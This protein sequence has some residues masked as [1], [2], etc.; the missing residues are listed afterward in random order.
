MW[1]V[2]QIRTRHNQLRW[3]PR[4]CITGR[5]LTKVEAASR[6][7]EMNYKEKGST[8]EIEIERGRRRK[9]RNRPQS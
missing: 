7:A 5:F 1:D 6:A 8:R 3:I 4:P 9:E 2:D